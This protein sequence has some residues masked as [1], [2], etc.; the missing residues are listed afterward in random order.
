MERVS[1]VSETGTI[2]E[3]AAFHS[4]VEVNLEGTDVD[5]LYNTMVDRVLESLA[6]FQM[7]G[8]NWTFRS[9]ISLEIDT[10][11][12]EPLRGNYYIPLPKALASKKAIINMKNKDN[13]CFNW[14]VTRVLNPVERDAERIS[15]ILRVQAEKQL[16]MNGIEYPVSL[17]AMDKVE[18]QNPDISANVF[19]YESNVKVYPLR[20]SKHFNRPAVVNL[21]LISDGEGKQHYCLVK[22]MSRLLSSQTSN[23][24]V[25][26]H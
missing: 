1:I 24:K 8:S 4:N 16:N 11:A 15:K 5:D 20:V 21:L 25:K 26:H 14:C 17:K 7:Q 19:G 6:T 12:Y 23:K 3:P 13:E 18:K 9:I 2:V 22:D 10:V